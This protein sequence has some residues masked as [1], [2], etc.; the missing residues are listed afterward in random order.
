MRDML[1]F[2]DCVW[3]VNFF[4]FRKLPRSSYKIL[5][6]SIIKVNGNEKFIN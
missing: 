5:N 2:K 3:W 6:K 1:N 4:L